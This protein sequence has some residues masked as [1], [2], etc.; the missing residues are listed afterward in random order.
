MFVENLGGPWSSGAWGPGPNGP[1]VDLPL[2]KD[3][4]VVLINVENGIPKDVINL[5]MCKVNGMRQSGYTTC[6]YACVCMSYHDA[7]SGKFP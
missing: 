5:D 7:T 2:M 4:R 6:V 1:V 3:I